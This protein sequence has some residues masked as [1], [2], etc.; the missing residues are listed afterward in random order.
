TSTRL[1][2][3]SVGSARYR[4]GVKLTCPVNPDAGLLVINRKGRQVRPCGTL[5]D[6]NRSGL[7]LQNHN[8]M[9]EGTYARRRIADGADEETLTR[10]HRRE[11]EAS[12]DCRPL[13]C[14][15]R[16]VITVDEIAAGS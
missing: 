15:R 13:E 3:N 9:L 1:D 2:L 12:T 4:G 6:R 7:T 14:H 16:G 5:I 8:A 10:R 11:D